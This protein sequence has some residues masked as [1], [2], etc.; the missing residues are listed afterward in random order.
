MRLVCDCRMV[1]SSTQR[2]KHRCT[3]KVIDKD[4]QVSCIAESYRTAKNGAAK[5]VVRKIKEIGQNQQD[6]ADY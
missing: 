6:M 5:R 4:V 2:S 1:Y 3:I